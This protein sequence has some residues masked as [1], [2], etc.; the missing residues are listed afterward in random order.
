MIKMVPNK[1][2]LYE[3][4]I[5]RTIEWLQLVLDRNVHFINLYTILT[6]NI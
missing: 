4:E 1:D 6:L 2:V 5:K 3:L